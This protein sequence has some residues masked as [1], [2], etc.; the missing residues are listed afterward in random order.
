MKLYVKQKVFSWKDKFNIYDE[1]G[2]EAYWVE[3]EVFSIGKKL[4]LFDKDNN[5]KAH[6]HQKVLSF[7]PRYFIQINGNDVSEVVKH[8]TLF[9]QKFSVTGYDWQVDGDFLAHEYE[10]HRDN[11][12]VAT[13]SKE[14][15]TLGD[16]Y[17]IN[18]TDGVDPVAVISV[19]LIIDAILAQSFTAIDF[20]SE[21][22]T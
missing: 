21:I 7:L 3:G 18:I 20:V 13:I 19:V 10:I 16:A 6:I 9:N 8:F 22:F 14:W 17:S 2:N 12:T 4:D 1:Y 15:F 11:Y 5:H